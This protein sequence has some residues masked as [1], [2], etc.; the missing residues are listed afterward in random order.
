MKEPHS[1]SGIRGRPELKAEYEK[2][3]RSPDG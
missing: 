1:V 3:R 2:L